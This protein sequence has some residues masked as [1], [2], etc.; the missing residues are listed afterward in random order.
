MQLLSSAVDWLE[1]KISYERHVRR[2]NDVL[3]RWWP[4]RTTNV[5]QADFVTRPR[6]SLTIQSETFV[7]GSVF[8]KIWSNNC[9]CF[10]SNECQ[11]RRASRIW[12]IDGRRVKVQWTA[13]MLTRDEAMDFFWSYRVEVELVMLGD[14]SWLTALE[15]GGADCIR[16][17]GGLWSTLIIVCC[18]EED[19]LQMKWSSKTELL[20][21]TWLTG[22]GRR[23]ETSYPFLSLSLSGSEWRK[24]RS[25]RTAY[26]CMS[27]MSVQGL[28]NIVQW[29]LSFILSC[30]QED[31]FIALA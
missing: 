3:S 6:D 29:E 31:D 2:S 15:D 7:L 20:T 5:L 1:T 4:E 8:E 11:H 17:L 19:K 25:I 16:P 27:N 10:S 9:C 28:T 14:R 12:I 26:R 30:I 24:R 21:S 18:V 13:S 23:K 22:E